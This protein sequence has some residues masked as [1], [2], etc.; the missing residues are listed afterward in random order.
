M[1]TSSETEQNLHTLN[2]HTDACTCENPIPVLCLRSASIL[3]YRPRPN[4]V[5]YNF[6]QQISPFPLDLVKAE[7]IKYPKAKLCWVQEEPKNMG[8]WAYVR[9][10]FQTALGK[11]GSE[12][13]IR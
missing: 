3:R 13:T 6:L 11:E 8:P 4:A 10:R 1:R 9:P 7:M 2:A 12:R 5:Q